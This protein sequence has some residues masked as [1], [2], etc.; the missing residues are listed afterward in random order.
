MTSNYH[1]LDKELNAGIGSALKF[2]CTVGGRRREIHTEFWVGNLKERGH[3]KG[4]KC[5]WGVILK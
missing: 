2:S 3:L 4:C 1:F 5:R